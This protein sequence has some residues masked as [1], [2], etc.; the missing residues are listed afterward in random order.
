MPP[1]KSVGNC[2]RSDTVD[3]DAA[4]AQLLREIAGQDLK[5]AWL[6]RSRPPW[7]AGVTV[8]GAS[9]PVTEPLRPGIRVPLWSL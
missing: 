7:P 4:S 3:G 8:R 2:A 6:Q 1:L 9:A 5:T